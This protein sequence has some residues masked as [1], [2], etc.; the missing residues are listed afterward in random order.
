VYKPGLGH[1]RGT[2]E[3][4]EGASVYLVSNGSGEILTVRQVP[5]GAG[6]VYEFAQVP[7][8]DYYVAAFDHAV[9]GGLP[10][11]D[12]PAAIVPFASSARVEAGSTASIDLRLNRW[13]W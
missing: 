7:P 10:A 3:R 13:P 5:C 1:V 2:V 11:T 6:G 12:L 9:S 8:G 4:G